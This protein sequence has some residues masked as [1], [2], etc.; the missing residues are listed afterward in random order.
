MNMRVL[1]HFWHI[2]FIQ[3]G[4]VLSSDKT[5]HFDEFSQMN[6]TLVSNH[7]HN[8]NKGIYD[9]L[10]VPLSVFVNQPTCN[11]WPWAIADLLSVFAE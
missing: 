2:D 3:F 4:C 10:Q 8:Q 5:D 9:L 11:S 7:E 1:V 6:H